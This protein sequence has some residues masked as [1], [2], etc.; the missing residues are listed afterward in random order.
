LGGGIGFSV[1]EGAFTTLVSLEGRMHTLEEIR[2]QP[3]HSM[4]K[5]VEHDQ[6]RRELLDRSFGILAE[7]GYTE[8]T[9]RQLAV[10]LGVSTGTLY[11]YFP[12]KQAIFEQLVD[13]IVERDVEN[14]TAEV[15][16]LESS[17]Q[18]LAALFH[19]GRRESNYFRKQL[20]L[21]IDYYR[22]FEP[23]QIRADERRRNVFARYERV[24]V[25]QIGFDDPILFKVLSCL[26]DGMTV[27]EIYLADEVPLDEMIAVITRMLQSHL[28]ARRTAGVLTPP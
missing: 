14:I 10:A 22:R 21:L 9:M 15:K 16:H 17:E 19:Y 27:Q 5:I 25:E 23:D 28:A 12:S 13:R 7:R 2:P 6:Y 18:K 1:D 3:F 26:F 11:H 8:V 4:P 20:L 24:F